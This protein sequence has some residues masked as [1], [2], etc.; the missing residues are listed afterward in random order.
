VGGEVTV[1]AQQAAVLVDHLLQALARLRA[2]IGHAQAAHPDDASRW[3]NAR[4]ASD[5]MDFDQQAQTA[6]NMALRT[7]FPLCGEPVPDYGHFS[8]DA[9]GLLQR[10]DRADALLQGLRGRLSRNVT[11]AATVHFEAGQAQHEAPATEFLL[12]FALPNL[13]FHLSMA[14]ALLRH[15]AVPLGKADYDGWHGYPPV[16]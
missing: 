10:I 14:Y 2:W 3:L 1:T 7:A 9:T 5:M 15:T 6:V 8:R 12:S 13:H 16:R 4:L 11:T